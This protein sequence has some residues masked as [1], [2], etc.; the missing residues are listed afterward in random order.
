MDRR[1]LLQFLITATT[2]PPSPDCDITY[3]TEADD[4]VDGFTIECRGLSC[5]AGR[6]D[7]GTWHL[8][9]TIWITTTM[10]FAPTVTRRKNPSATLQEKLMSIV[11]IETAFDGEQIYQSLVARLPCKPDPD[12]LLAK[13][14]R[15][16][17][18]VE[19]P[20]L[21]TDPNDDEDEDLDFY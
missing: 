20:L 2:P 11:G 1:P 8:S 17:A 16:M 3:F 18:T 9:F 4:G 10:P 21:Y 12:E 19:L 7:D 6:E 13:M 14:E 5:G 15:L